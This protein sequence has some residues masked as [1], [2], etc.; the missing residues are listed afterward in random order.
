MLPKLF[1]YGIKMLENS[2][3]L[4]EFRREEESVSEIE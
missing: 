3:I 4:E 2:E 1:K